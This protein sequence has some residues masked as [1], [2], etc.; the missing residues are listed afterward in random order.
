M[1]RDGQAPKFMGRRNRNGVPYL[2]VSTVLAIGL[3]AYTQV[4]SSASIVITYL[5]GLV[6]S[7]Q[8]VNW[9]V[10]S[11]SWIK[12]NRALKAQGIS[13]DTLPARSRFQP[14]AAYY[15]FTCACIVTFWQGYG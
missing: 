7:A 6:G 11:G 8:L 4:S 9:I 10:M 12:W 5:T 15:A 14:F 2:A 3:I 1:G 13:R